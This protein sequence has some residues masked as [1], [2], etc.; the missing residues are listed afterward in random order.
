MRAVKKRYAKNAFVN[1]KAYCPKARRSVLNRLER[2]TLRKKADGGVFTSQ[3]GFLLPIAG[4]L[5]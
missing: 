4:G 1:I 3:V 2:A 5:S